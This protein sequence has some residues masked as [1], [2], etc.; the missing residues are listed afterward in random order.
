M[1][2]LSCCCG[3]NFETKKNTREKYACHVAFVGNKYNREIV[4]D[5]DLAMGV[6]K[7]KVIGVSILKVARHSGENCVRTLLILKHINIK[8]LFTSEF[9]E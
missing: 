4:S 5:F 7:E 2:G 9:V 8:A 3:M 1:R 6:S